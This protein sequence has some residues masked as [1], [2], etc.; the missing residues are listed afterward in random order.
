MKHMYYNM[1]Q[2]KKES[3]A[4]KLGGTLNVILMAIFAAAVIGG[5]IIWTEIEIVEARKAQYIGSCPM[6]N[7]HIVWSYA[8][9]GENG[10]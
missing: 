3:L 6:A 10:K 8:K 1:K 5:G 7:Q 4:E 2:K 9:V